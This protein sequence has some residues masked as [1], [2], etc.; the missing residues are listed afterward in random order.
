[1]VLAAITQGFRELLQARGEQV[2][3]RTVR[4]LVPVS[5][6][7]ADQKGSYDNRVSAMYAELPVGLADPV[8]RL[9][10]ISEQLKGLKESQQA[11]AGETLTSLAGFAPPILLSAGTRLAMRIPQ[12]NL[13]TVTTNVPGPRVQLYAA[14]RKMLEAFPY[15]PLAGRVRIGVA[16][17]SYLDSLNFGVTGDYDSNPDLDI[18]PRGICAGLADLK[19]AAEAVA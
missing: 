11:V 12:R 6:R 16:I 15:V 5:V 19:K 14:G 10:S 9:H 13:N 2:D 7:K 1:V 17:F 3:A 4:T 8:E 18:L